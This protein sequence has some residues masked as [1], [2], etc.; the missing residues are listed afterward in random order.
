MKKIRSVL[1]VLFLAAAATASAEDRNENDPCIDVN[2]V[3]LCPG[4]KVRVSNQFE[5]EVT[6]AE[7][8]RIIEGCPARA[9]YVSGTAAPVY[10]GYVHSIDKNKATVVVNI[11]CKRT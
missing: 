5:T 9:E 7:S 6:Y 8:Y 2:G 11:P 10:R 1:V 4:D 3:K